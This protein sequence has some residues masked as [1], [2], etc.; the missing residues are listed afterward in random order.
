MEETRG[1]NPL[2]ST[3]RM[4]N[5]SHILTISSVVLLVGRQIYWFVTEWFSHSRKKKTIPMTPSMYAKRSI[6]GALSIL[7]LAQLFGLELFPF[8]APIWVE[9][10]GFLCV[11]LSI[12]ISVMARREIEDNWSHAAEY[13][14]KKGHTLTTSGI[15]GWIRHPIYLAVILSVLGVE[16]QTRSLLVVLLTSLTFLVLYQQGKMEELLLT[17]QFGEKYTRY[18]RKTA[19]FIPHIV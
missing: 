5:P 19:M 4:F 18:M 6:S 17:K 11:L 10:V 2:G 9:V 1:S 7:L 8:Q 12:E 15:Y 14:I 16:L 13:Q 3:F